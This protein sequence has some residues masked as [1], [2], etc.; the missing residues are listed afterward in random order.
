MNEDE[1]KEWDVI[2]FIGSTER[3]VVYDISRTHYHTWNFIYDVHPDWPMDKTPY[4]KG[5]CHEFA[6]KVGKYVRETRE[7]VDDE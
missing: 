4:A 6:V 3:W 2:T 1:F 5:F 7:V